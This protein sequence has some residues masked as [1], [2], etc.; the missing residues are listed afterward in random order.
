M[1]DRRFRCEEGYLGNCPG[2]CI[3]SVDM[4]LIDWETRAKDRHEPY[5]CPLQGY[6]HIGCGA[7]WAEIDDTGEYVLE[8]DV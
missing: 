4:S 5:K 3:L 7:L 6:G 2:N 1:V 8:D